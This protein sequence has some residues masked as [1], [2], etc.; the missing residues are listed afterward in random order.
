MSKYIEMGFHAIC[1][2][3][4]SKYDE[5]KLSNVVHIPHYGDVRRQ[6]VNFP[7]AR[8]YNLVG[9]YYAPI[10][11]IADPSCI[12][13]LHGNAS[14]QL[15]G[16]FLVNIFCPAGVSV[17]CFDSCACGHSEGEYISL[18]YFESDD[19]SSAIALLRVQYGIHRIALWGRSMG[20]ATTFFVLDNEPQIAAT[21]ADSPFCSLPQLIQD[22]G[23]KWNIPGCLTSTGVKIVSKTV[24]QKANFDIYEVEPIKHAPK[25]KT[26]LMIIHGEADSFIPYHHSELLYAAY[27]CEEKQLRIVPHAEHNSER[28]IEVIVEAIMFVANILDAPVVV[29]DIHQIMSNAYRHFE[30]AADMIHHMME[31]DADEQHNHNN[32]NRNGNNNNNRNT[33]NG[34]NRNANTSNN[35]NNHNANTTNNNTNANNN[36]NH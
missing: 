24:K 7:N 21:I 6:P 10:E 4:R 32:N 14:C 9:S 28:P 15:E 18:G 5:R 19:V 23:L 34:N 12:I 17:L 8:G 20:A 16:T 29:D 13:Y 22:L 36:N 27:G 2:P 1:R 31:D 26:P 3:P 35:N 11:K 33:N 25:C 30:N